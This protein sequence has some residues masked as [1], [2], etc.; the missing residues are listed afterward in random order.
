MKFKF[1]TIA[2]IAFFGVASAHA[3][4]YT[5]DVELKDGSKATIRGVVADSES[6]AARI[7]KEDNE[8]IKWISCFR[9]D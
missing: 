2:L 8:Y 4:T 5:C 6:Q 1:I 7:A 3:G 9:V